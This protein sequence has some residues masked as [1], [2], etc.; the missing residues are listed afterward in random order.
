M[1]AQTH[2][3]EQLD[4]LRHDKACG[5]ARVRVAIEVDSFLG[6][7]NAQT[8]YPRI[9]WHARGSDK[10]HY[11]ALGC[12]HELT[13]PEQIQQTFAHDNQ[14]ESPRYYGGLAFDPRQHDWQG[15]GSCRF[16]LPRIELIRRGECTHLCLNLWFDEHN[17]EAE[18]DS[19]IAALASLQPE[20]PLPPLLPQQWQRHD[21]P[22]FPQWQTLVAAVTAPD[23]QAQTPKVVLSRESRLEGARV[24]PWS[25]L[26]SWTLQAEE[27][28]QFGFQ[29]EPEQAFIA[30]SPE[31]LYR[32]EQRHLYTEALAGTIRRCGDEAADALLAAELMGDGKNRLENRL[33]QADILQRLAP[34]THDA[35]LTEPRVL[36]LRLLQHLKCDIEAELHPTVSDGQLLAALHPTP[37]V[38]GAPREAAL[39]FIRDHEPHARGWYAGAC[40]MLSRETSE[41]SVAIRSA[42]IRPQTVT[43]FAGA[44]IV[45]GSEPAA[46]W[47][48]LDNKIAN[49]L[50]LLG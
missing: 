14:D 43:L 22:D 48:E 12:I 17:R 38:G 23:F 21:S 39:R 4:A 31:R 47:A 13:G 26:A 45:A 2:I 28:F 27:C 6:W 50:S 11:V 8:L 9:Y 37:A 42:L 7:L 20:A 35:T 30:C 32:R 15:F 16:V 29:F 10:P 36:K 33:V 1:L 40:G 24:N 44:G 3:K 46:E 41:F 34:L 25:L 19:A 18:L 5:L 49:V